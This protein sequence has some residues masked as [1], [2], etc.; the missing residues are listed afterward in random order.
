MKL[1]KRWMNAWAASDDISDLCMGGSLTVG[2][3]HA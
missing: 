2:G 1:V 3:A